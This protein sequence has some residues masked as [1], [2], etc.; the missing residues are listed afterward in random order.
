MTIRLD[1]DLVEWLK[2][3]GHRRLDAQNDALISRRALRRAALGLPFE[4]PFH[5]REL[6]GHFPVA[7]HED[8]HPTQ[9]P[10]LSVADLAIHPP[11]DGAI[12]TDDDFL[13]LESRT[14]IASEPL[15]PKRDHRGLSLYAVAVWR[16]RRVLKH[17]VVGQQ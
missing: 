17:R 4:S 14:G 1:H 9:M 5:V 8:V 10:R 13:G 12:T 15:P 16:G 3:N 11:H 7:Y 2:K 6:G